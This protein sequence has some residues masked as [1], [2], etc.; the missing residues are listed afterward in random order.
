MQ[1]EKFKP[2]DRAPFS[3]WYRAI[4]PSHDHTSEIIVAKGG[5][6]PTC[7]KCTISPSYELIGALKGYETFA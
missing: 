5:V 1:K 6:F 3:G 4:H 2:G 7:P